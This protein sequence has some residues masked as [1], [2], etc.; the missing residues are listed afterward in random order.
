MRSRVLLVVL[1]L[2]V[3]ASF[4]QPNALPLL[5]QPLIPDC[6][7]PGSPQFT[8]TVNGTG[9]VSG[10]VLKW[11]GSARTT[12]VISN[13]QVQA[14]INA[15]DVAN[16]QTARVTVTN[17]S[18]GTSSPVYFPV[19]NSSTTVQ[20]KFLENKIPHGG[21]MVVGDFN[22]DGK[23]D[24]VIGNINARNKLA[25]EQVYLGK[26]DGSFKAPINTGPFKYGASP[27]LIGDFNG[28]GKPDLLML[29]SQH[30]AFVLL[31]QGNGKFT[32]KPVFGVGGGKYMATADFNGDG[33]LDLVFVFNQRTGGGEFD[34]YFGKGDGTFQLA[35]AG[36]ITFSG[37]NP[38]IGDF[39]GDGK[40]DLAIPDGPN[41]IG[42][43]LG[44]G[45]GTFQGEVLY[46]TTN[47][48]GFEVITADFNGDGKLDLITAGGDVFL[49]NGDGTFKDVGVLP[50]GGM[51]SASNP[52]LFV[53]DFNGNG[54]L[55]LIDGGLY[56]GNGDGTF[57][58]PINVGGI[59][60]DFNG[61]GKLDL[62]SLGS[63]S[64]HSAI[65]VALQK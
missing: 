1:V 24:V 12:Q 59:V 9:F 47:G 42:V 3:T 21:L 64:G 44:N 4:A 48:A 22:N 56:L 40:L 34:I 29:N 15:A 60:G 5:N 53:G 11:N 51:Q 54:K 49:G 39:N 17:P 55:D 20:F 63:I 27:R 43:W 7:A 13:S 36:G 16:A 32:A 25:T 2:F 23:P 30:N 19:R 61:D 57:Q 8:L 35:F 62:V 50:G 6:V 52:S 33:K 31:G 28:D 10:A 18:G 26:G 14:T 37:S 46:H 65:S 45:D 38:A 58:N 41:N